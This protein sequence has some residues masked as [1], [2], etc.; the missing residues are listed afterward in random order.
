MVLPY[1]CLAQLLWSVMES[2]SQR[3]DMKNLLFQSKL[4]IQ[5][6]H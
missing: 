1:F 5:R 2:F 4:F 6:P 3:V